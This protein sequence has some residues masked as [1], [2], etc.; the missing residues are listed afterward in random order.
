MFS[1][2]IRNAH[3]IHHSSRNPRCSTIERSSWYQTLLPFKKNAPNCPIVP[4]HSAELDFERDVQS[5]GKEAGEMEEPENRRSPF[6]HGDNFHERPRTA[7]RPRNAPARTRSSRAFARPAFLEQTPVMGFCK[8][9]Q[10][11][12]LTATGSGCVCGRGPRVFVCPAL[13]S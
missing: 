4:F 5:T 11:I 2:I 13:Y 10:V 8:L 9:E 7:A 12:P 6:A 1:Y 3:A